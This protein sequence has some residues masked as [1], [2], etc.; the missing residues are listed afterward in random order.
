M[1]NERFRPGACVV[2]TDHHGDHH[3]MTPNGEVLRFLRT[4]KT[5]NSC[6]D[7][8]VCEV[9]MMVNLATDEADAR[10]IIESYKKE[11]EW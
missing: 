1:A 8:S 5:I 4:T 3:I 6:D 10:R 9:T 2:F 7:Y 11:R